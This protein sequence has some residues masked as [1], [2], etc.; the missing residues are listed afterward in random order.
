MDLIDM[1]ECFRR[2]NPDLIDHKGEPPVNPSHKEHVA[3]IAYN[4][5]T[6]ILH[7]GHVVQAPDGLF[8]FP[9]VKMDENDVP[10]VT[11]NPD[12]RPL[13]A[14]GHMIE[15]HGVEMLHRMALESNPHK[16]QLISYCLL[17]DDQGRIAT[18][19]RLKYIGGEATLT[20]RLSA[21]YGGHFIHSDI[22]LV[23][24][25]EG[26]DD[27]VYD[28]PASFKKHFLRELNGEIRLLRVSDQ[29]IV[30]ITEDMVQALGFLFAPNPDKAEDPGNYHLALVSRC[31][32]HFDCEVVKE[33][34]SNPETE[35][36][37]WLRP[38]D[39]E[40]YLADNPTVESWARAILT[41]YKYLPELLPVDSD[42]E[43]QK[44]TDDLADSSLEAEEAGDRP[45]IEDDL[46]DLEPGE[47]WAPGEAVADPENLR[48]LNADFVDE[49][50]TA[51]PPSSKRGYPT[52]DHDADS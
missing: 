33:I 48:S 13:S 50:P 25:I 2:Y 7:S 3:A 5:L 36:T 23:P 11:T 39:I 38:E 34:S 1:A 26:G 21:F 15:R 41:N 4:Y 10:Y 12:T 47:G 44:D 42:H 45:L 20:D 35:F 29:S 31:Q 28:M 37:G 22:V 16:L 19:R 27:E 43:P 49:L 24:A 46:S 40:E 14:Y 52:A 6:Q 51:T 18:Y 9:E 30:E 17:H 32:V 8:L